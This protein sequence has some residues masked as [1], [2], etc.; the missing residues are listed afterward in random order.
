VVVLEV[1]FLDLALPVEP[2]GDPPV[3]A[4]DEALGT[5]PVAGKLVGAPHGQLLDGI[6][7][8]GVAEEAQDGLDLPHVSGRQTG[9]IPVLDEPSQPFVSDGPNFHDPRQQKV[10]NL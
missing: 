10:V 1:Q 7:P 9:G 2:E 4:D 8:W 6:D 5:L 3:A